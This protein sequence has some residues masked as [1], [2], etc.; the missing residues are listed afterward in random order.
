MTNDDGTQTKNQ[1]K[2]RVVAAITALKAQG[3]DI[4]PY[5]VSGEAQVPR[6]T[7]Y[8]D[9]ELMDLIYKERNGEDGSHLSNDEIQSKI[10]EL[11][12]SNQALNEQIWDLE[13]Q[14]ESMTKLKQD[15]YVQGFQAGIEEAAKRKTAGSIGEVTGSRPAIQVEVPVAAEETVIEGTDY[16]A[17]PVAVGL[18]ETSYKFTEPVT[19]VPPS[20]GGDA[21]H[22]ITAKNRIDE[23]TGDYEPLSDSHIAGDFHF[24]DSLMAQDDSYELEE[25]AA[26]QALAPGPAPEPTPTP[27]PTPAATP[28]PEPAPKPQPKAAVAEETGEHDIFDD[29]ESVLSEQNAPASSGPDMDFTLHQERPE[30]E[31]V[32]PVRKKKNF[33]DI[34]FGLSTESDSPNGESEHEDAVAAGARQAAPI[35]Q[36]AGVTAQAG[37]DSAVAQMTRDG[38][39]IYNIAR[40][41]PTISSSAY[42]P[43]VELSWKDLQTV[44]NFSVASLKDYAKPGFGNEPGALGGTNFADSS[45]QQPK[46]VKTRHEAAIETSDSLDLPGPDPRRTGDRLQAL[47]DPR[48]LL[49]SEPIVDLDALDIFDDLDDYV[50]LDKIE[51]ISDVVSKPKAEEP[52]MGGDELRELIKGRIKQ[53]ADIPNE[54]SAPRMTQPPPAGGAAKES[55]PAGGGPRNKFIGGAKA[56]QEPPSA[57]PAFVVKTIPPEIRKSFMI[58]G[59]KPEEATTKSVIEAWKK[60]IASPGVHPDLGGDTEAAVY[61]NTA[62]D[63]LVRWLDQQAPKLGKKFGQAHKP[64]PPKP[65]KDEDA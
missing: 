1:E 41:G 53:A 16:E 5:T 44:Y 17:A 7:L 51:V 32:E 48:N 40:S 3:A 52:S 42:N 62:K 59:L 10:A 46:P 47:S 19:A 54:P 30:P 35:D 25:K 21:S 61:L 26:P 27:A 60:Q 4:N 43:L 37:E 24:G 36:Q 45:T 50:D 22:K 31:P 6:S 13:K 34:D 2:E 14:L 12:E 39:G 18:G 65:K 23:N 20:N 9:P 55:A 49:D 8:R 11:E 33:P 29:I 38:D 63:M 15:A 57:V 58:L 56:G 64:E 28:A